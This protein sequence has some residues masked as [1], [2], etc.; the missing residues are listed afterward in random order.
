[1]GLSLN[2]IQQGPTAATVTASNENRESERERAR[3]REREGERE[4]KRKRM[5]KEKSRKK[6]RVSEYCGVNENEKSFERVQYA[7]H[8][9][10]YSVYSQPV[11]EQ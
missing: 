5:R 4:N 9:H 7:S 11:S 8:S 1:M 2:D 3:K 10:I 6:D